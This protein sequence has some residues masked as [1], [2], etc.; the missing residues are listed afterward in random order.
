MTKLPSELKHDFLRE[1]DPVFLEKF[2]MNNDKLTL[3]G[4]IGVGVLTTSLIIGAEVPTYAT[5][6]EPDLNI[7]S[8]NPHKTV[9]K[10][11][12]D[13]LKNISFF[14]FQYDRIKIGIDV[15]EDDYPEIEVIEV[16]AVKRMV[17]QF[18]NPVKLE[19]S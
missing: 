6:L 18:K 5:M 2:Q 10:D 12:P 11:Y 3:G 1:L 16:P 17:F 9:L 8:E 4:I 7:N 14:S 15:V 19:F 13:Y